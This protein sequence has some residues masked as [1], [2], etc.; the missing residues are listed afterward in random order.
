[1]IEPL[2]QIEAV[3]PAQ[4]EMRIMIA[5]HGAANKA[6]MFYMNQETDLANFWGKGLRPNCCIT[7]IGCHVASANEI[8][9]EEGSAEGNS[10]FDSHIVYEIGK[11]EILYD[12]ELLKKAGNL[13]G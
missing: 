11:D 10:K 1:M 13:L 12:P 8:G 4:S 3:S 7:K 9:K 5:A 2:A 6:M